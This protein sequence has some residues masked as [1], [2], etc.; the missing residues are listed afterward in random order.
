LGYKKCQPKESGLTVEDIGVCFLRTEMYKSL[1]SS[2]TEFEKAKEV[3]NEL[4]EEYCNVAD[5]NE[6]NEL[7]KEKV[8]EDEDKRDDDNDN[9]ILPE[10][11]MFPGF[12]AFMVWG[13]FADPSNRLPIFYVGDACKSTVMTKV[14]KGKS[15]ALLKSKERSNDTEHNRGYTIN[16]RISYESL[17]L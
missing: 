14:V 3:D 9:I 8:N 11:Y 13:P 6:S 7:E 12:M 5:E 16:Q 4:E 2:T 15:D 1:N 17:M 10:G